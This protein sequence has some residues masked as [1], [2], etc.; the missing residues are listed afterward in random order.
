MGVSAR[1]IGARDR[2]VISKTA[3]LVLLLALALPACKIL[4]TACRRS[5]GGADLARRHRL[6]SRAAWSRRCGT[7]RCCLI[8]K[9]RPG[10]LPDVLAL[11]R[12]S[13]D[14]AGAKYGFRPKE[15]TSPWTLV[16]KIEGKIVA[17]ETAS[18]AATIDVDVDGDGKPDA[19]IQIGPAMRGTALRDSLD[20][21]SFNTFTNQIDFARFG[22]SFNQH[23]DRT[24]LQ[25]LPRDGLV[26]SQGHGRRR[27]R[28]RKGRRAAARHAGDADPRAVVVSAATSA[29]AAD[30]VVLRLEGVTKVYSGTIAVKGADFEI[31]RGAVNVLVGENGA[32]KS[33]LMKI[34]AGVEQPS[35]GRIVLDGK[36]V[37]LPQCRGGGRPR[38]RHR[39]P[40]AQFVRQPVRRRKHLRLARDNPA[41]ARHRPSRAGTA[42]R[43][44][45]GAP[46]DGHRSAHA[47]RGAA[48]RP[49]AARRDRQGG[50]AG[51][52]HPD[53]GRADL[54]PERRRGR[55][56]LSCHRRPQGARRRHRLHLASP[57]GADPHRRLH[58]R[59]ARR[60][61]HRPGA[62][63]QCRRRLDRPPDD[64]LGRQGLRQVGRPCGR[65]RGVPRRGHHLAARHRRPFGRPRLA[66]ARAGA[67]S[68]AST[69]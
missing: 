25:A 37:V 13:P 62:H 22:K 28:A 41:A 23:V 10:P 66:V 16:A 34:I 45:A 3:A 48:H 65:R 14:E 52:P 9:P 24:L 43:R 12:K 2:P 64:R 39:L 49:A 35:A 44:A 36:A 11:A 33:T 15:G 6:R 32:G 59:V 30:D 61:R 55:D 53:H 5:E 8:S 20:F 47:G 17:A 29:H 57:G 40:G 4:P 50:V 54:G 42:G 63:G 26:G 56:P 51:R 58:H 27:V 68:S 69:V 60:A 18:R 19:T 31:R 38:H 7:P 21:V 1:R 67:R 46:G